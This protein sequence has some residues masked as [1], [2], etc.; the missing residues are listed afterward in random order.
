[1]GQSFASEEC[2]AFQTIMGN[3]GV[4]GRNAIIEIVDYKGKESSILNG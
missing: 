1:M 4:D 2:S 3:V